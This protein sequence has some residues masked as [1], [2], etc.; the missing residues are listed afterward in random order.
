M[1]IQE[2]IKEGT[3]KRNYRVCE[4]Q[5]SINPAIAYAMNQLACLDDKDRV[6]DPTTGSAT[7]LIERQLLKPA[8]CVGVD[9]DPRALECAK[10]N[11]E[12]ANVEITLKHGD[13]KTLKFPE[14]YFTKIIANLPYGIHT[15]S[16]EKNIE[17]YRFLADKS[18]HWL[19]VGGRAV[20]LT[21]AKS[22]LRNSFHFNSSWQLESEIPIHV[23]GLHLSI[24]TYQRIN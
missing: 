5:S 17:L 24:F 8:I 16:R 18:I 1:N 21:N 10:R 3:F 19:R 15:G 2:L 13:I 9:I 11:S 14:G 20:F 4:L 23:G 22:L 7:I 12:A 6:L